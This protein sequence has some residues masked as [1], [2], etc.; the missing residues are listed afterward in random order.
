ME[1]RQDLLAAIEGYHNSISPARRVPID[2]LQI[3]LHALPTT[4]NALMDP[5]DCPLLLQGAL[6]VPQLWSIHTPALAIASSHP[7]LMCFWDLTEEFRITSLLFLK[8]YVT[9]ITN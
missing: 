7:G 9:S 8:N 5:Y 4:H 6:S 3:S 1:Q 2:V